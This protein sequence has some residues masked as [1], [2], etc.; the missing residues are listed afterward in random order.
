[1]L[2]GTIIHYQVTHLIFRSYC[3][4]HGLNSDIIEGVKELLILPVLTLLASFA[5][6]P[7][8]LLHNV[9]GNTHNLQFLDGHLSTIAFK[10]AM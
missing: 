8:W 5:L 9:P 10:I 6:W 3:K 2:K 4:F 1:M 7:T